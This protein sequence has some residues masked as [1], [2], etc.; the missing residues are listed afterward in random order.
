[1]NHSQTSSSYS[2]FEDSTAAPTSLNIVRN[3]ISGDGSRSLSVG[4][5]PEPS[6]HWRDVFWL[7][8]FALHLILVGLILGVLGLNRFKKKDRL[9]IDRYTI[10]NREDVPSLTE[11]FWPFY[12]AAGAVGV[13]LGCAWLLLLGSRGNDMMKFAVHIL[14]T[15]LAVVSVLCFWDEQ[16]FWGVSFAIGAVLQ[17]L[18]VIS[19]IDRLPYTMLILQR[20]VNM[21]WSVPEVMKVSCAFMLVTLLWLA[22]WSFGAAGVVAWSIS[23]GGR[24]WL[25]VV[26]GFSL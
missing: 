10:A 25:L 19:V 3:S 20:A 7:V 15:Y 23:H 5:V 18:Y 22:L 12:A 17:F 13:L 2:S 14:T 21:V 8:T 9:N 26:S 1:M 6:R 16:F 4:H 11:D 24:W